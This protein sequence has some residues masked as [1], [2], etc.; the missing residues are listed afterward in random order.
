MACSCRSWPSS[1]ERVVKP[2][3]AIAENPH[4]FIVV[5]GDGD[6][7]SLEV[8]GTLPREYRPY[9]AARASISSIE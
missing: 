6:R 7:L 2:G 8:I 5:G 4:H 1:L 9:G 3:A